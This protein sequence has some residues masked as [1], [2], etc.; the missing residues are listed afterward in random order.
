M[1][2]HQQTNWYD[3]TN[4]KCLILHHKP[5]R[6]DY[7]S[8]STK[9]GAPGAAQ[10]LIQVRYSRFQRKCLEL[11]QSHILTNKSHT[12]SKSTKLV[13][14]QQKSTGDYPFNIII[15][16]SSQVTVSPNRPY[17]REN[18]SVN[19]VILYVYILCW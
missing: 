6:A 3:D 7:I 11:L 17:G 10:I 1:Y 4:K 2:T 12:S 13:N 16:I 15:D 18:I 9:I 19:M 5:F 8:R 14:S